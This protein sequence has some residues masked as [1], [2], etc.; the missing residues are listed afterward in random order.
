MNYSFILKNI[1]NKNNEYPIYLRIFDN[2][3]SKYISL[4]AS[5]IKNNWNH[6]K[7]IV[8]SK[9]KNHI[10][11]NRKINAYSSVC[12]NIILDAI[13]KRESL[14]LSEFKKRIQN[15]ETTPFFD[16]AHEF[17]KNKRVKQTTKDEYLIRLNW[18]MKFIDKDIKLNQLNED[19]IENLIKKLRKESN[20]YTTIFN[21]ITV[22]SMVLNKAVKD[23]IIKYNHCK[24]IKI[25]KDTRTKEAL[26]E[27]EIII[28]EKLLNTNKISNSEKITLKLFLISSKTGM[29]LIDILNFTKKDIKTIII[30][31]VEYKLLVGFRGKD[32]VQFRVPITKETEKLI[33]SF[34]NGK[35]YIL[36]RFSDSSIQ[37]HIRN[38]RAVVP[39][40]KVKF[41]FHTARHSFAT[42]FSN[43]NISEKIL[44]PMMGH[45]R[46]STNRI[47]TH[48]SD[49][50][51]IKAVAAVIDK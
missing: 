33:M 26:N 27:N 45:T 14:S 41:T 3:S 5:V 4:K 2:S 34:D 25:K 28:L 49:T 8:K 12:E 16:Y 21:L 32:D 48:T 51:I 18:L 40:I 9:D 6:E 37:Y 11:K 35:K 31:K 17:L 7:R 39:E 10:T 19:Y 43:L 30:D 50:A 15:N 23:E 38:I 46:A 1:P 22:L 42:Y 44:L 24:N 36:R 29:S 13:L 20:S 47:Y